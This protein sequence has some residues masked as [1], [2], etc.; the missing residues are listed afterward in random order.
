MVFD[1]RIL[2]EATPEG[3]PIAEVLSP[4]NKIIRRFIVS[5]EYCLIVFPLTPEW[6]IQYNSTT[7]EFFKTRV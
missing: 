4:E 3:L 7:G 2:P 5:R 6:K 1:V